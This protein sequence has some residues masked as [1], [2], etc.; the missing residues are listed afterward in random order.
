MRMSCWSSDVCASD[1]ELATRL[2]DLTGAP[3]QV[4]ANIAQATTTSLE[5]FRSYLTGVDALNPWDLATAERSLLRALAIAHRK[6]VV[7]GK[8][9]SVR[10][11]SV[12]RRI[13]EKKQKV[14]H[15]Q[16]IITQN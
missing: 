8:R 10:V 6:S 2:L 7:S 4:R 13:I 9:V 14:A 5:A 16:L 15:M 12:G 11:A 1:L 3:A